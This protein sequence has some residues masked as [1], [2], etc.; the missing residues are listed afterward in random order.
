M[1]VDSRHGMISHR[2]MVTLLAHQIEKTTV[3]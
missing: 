1:A 3:C 2:T